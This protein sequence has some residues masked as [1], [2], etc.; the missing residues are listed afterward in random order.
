MVIL[1][2]TESMPLLERYDSPDPPKL[3]DIPVPLD[4]RR[5]ESV[6][7]TETIICKITSMFCIWIFAYYVR[8]IIAR[9]SLRGS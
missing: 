3:A 4:C 7:I 6:N 1:Y 5:T 2:N 9:A 8:D